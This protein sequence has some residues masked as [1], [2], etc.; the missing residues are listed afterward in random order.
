MLD[1]S[2]LITIGLI[3]VLTLLGGYARA[4]RRDRCLKSWEGFHVTVERTNGKLIWGV[5]KLEPTGMELAYR[6]S[7]QDEKHIESSYLLYTNE[8]GEIQAIY[9]YPDQ[10]APKDQLRRSRDIQ[11]AFHPGPLRRLGR[12]LRN[13]LSTATDSLN[14]VFGIVLG[15][16]QKTGSRYLAP[17]GG[18]AIKSLGSRVLGQVGG[19]YDPLLEHYIGRRVVAEVVEEDEIHEHVGI[20][21]EYSTDFIEIL[22]VHYPQDQTVVVNV[23]AAFESP[24]VCVT[25]V[26]KK[27][28]IT[29]NDP[30]PILI[31]SLQNDRGGE[32]FINAVV[33]NGETIQI[34]LGE[35]KAD[36]IKLH[37]QVIRELDMIVP[38]NR[39][40]IR[41]SA[42]NF[43]AQ[44]A[45]NLMTEL[46]FDVGRAL[47]SDKHQNEQELRLRE[48]LKRN[49]RDVTAAAN[50]GCLL[51]RQDVLDEAEYW[52]RCALEL[53]YSLPD[54]GRRVRME[55]REIE[56]RRL[57]SNRPL[58]G[59]GES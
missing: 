7:V 44:D 14:E 37:M 5:L 55:L 13:F 27:L 42:E 18:S 48:E 45:P 33:D 15:R 47:A 53:E 35:R 52:L 46:V 40:L 2:L 6:D 11:R 12:A 28:Q 19:T 8:Y 10:L 21:K 49:P 59:M 23:G 36:Q 20:F 17:E 31:R 1:S 22:E 58:F 54:G 32:E 29:N 16:V 38:Q 41:H 39:C 43:R 4:L 56:R 34:H 3:F 25:V 57:E 50:L 30:R 9:R 51:L 26:G 24:C